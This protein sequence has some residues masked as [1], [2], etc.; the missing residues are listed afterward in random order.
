[1]DRE[2]QAPSGEEHFSDRQEMDRHLPFPYEGG[3]FPGSLGAL[4][5]GTVLSGDVPA[6]SVTHTPDGCWLI[7]DGVSDPSL[8]GAS[9]ASHISHA[10]Q[11][12]SAIAEL[13]TMEPGHIAERSDPGKPWRI[14]ALASLAE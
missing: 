8:P 12:N 7:G 10:V 14:V 9:V 6:R 1:M 3:Q 4:I 2:G 5:Q 13:A 11:W